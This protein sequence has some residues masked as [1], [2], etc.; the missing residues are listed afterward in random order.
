MLEVQKPEDQRALVDY[1]TTE[2]RN[3][4]GDIKKI[5]MEVE[6]CLLGL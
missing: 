5:E 4:F 1:Y 6:K 2:N 3:H